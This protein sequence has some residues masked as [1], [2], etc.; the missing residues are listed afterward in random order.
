MEAATQKG[1][2]TPTAHAT[3]VAVWHNADL[4]LLGGVVARHLSSL[5][6]VLLHSISQLLQGRGQQPHPL[7]DMPPALLNGLI[8]PA[9]H[10]T[11]GC[12]LCSHT[13]S[14]SQDSVIHQLLQS[15]DQP[16]RRLFDMPLLS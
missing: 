10:L 3:I 12:T 4:E 8:Y 14:H 13:V 6:P 9:L 16:F 2:T 1:K 5:G 15:F 11:C 7:L